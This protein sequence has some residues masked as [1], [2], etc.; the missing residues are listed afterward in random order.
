MNILML[1]GNGYLGS[2]IVR[3]LVNEGHNVT[4]I[5]RADSDLSRLV[6]NESQIVFIPTSIDAIESAIQLL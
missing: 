2:K 3:R 4:Y 6:D 5:K 1:G